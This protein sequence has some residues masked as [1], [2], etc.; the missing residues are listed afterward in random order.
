MCVCVCARACAHVRACLR[1]CVGVGGWG[2]GE[3]VCVGVYARTCGCTRVLNVKYVCA[4]VWKKPA[5][6]VRHFERVKRFQ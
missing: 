6:R 2:G 5:W 1:V 4:V 3:C